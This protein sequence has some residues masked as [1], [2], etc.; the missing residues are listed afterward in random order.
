VETPYG[1]AGVDPAA[2]TEEPLAIAVIPDAEAKAD[3]LSPKPAPAVAAR[4]TERPRFAAMKKKVVREHH[5]RSY[6]GA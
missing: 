1:C 6:T 4:P 2:E 3:A 5:Q